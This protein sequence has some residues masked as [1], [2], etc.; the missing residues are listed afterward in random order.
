[1]TDR[2]NRTL[3]DEEQATDAGAQGLGR[4]SLMG[5]GFEVMLSG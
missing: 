2:P 4:V 3:I 1:M 5:A